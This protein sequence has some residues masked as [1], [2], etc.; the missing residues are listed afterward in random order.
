MFGRKKARVEHRGV[1]PGAYTSAHLEAQRT[2]ILGQAASAA[3]SSAAETGAG[4]LARAISSGRV[5]AG[6]WSPLIT[7]ALLQGLVRGMVYTGEAAAW[8][9]EAEGRF[10]FQ[11]VQHQWIDRDHLEIQE[12][13]PY[14][15]RTFHVPQA[16]VAVCLWSPNPEEPWRGISPLAHLGASLAANASGVLERESG[17]KVAHGYLLFHTPRNTFAPPSPERLAEVTEEIDNKLADWVGYEPGSVHSMSLS[18]G[19]VGQS[20]N[21]LG[22]Q[23]RFGFSPEMSVIEA[24]RWG[25]EETLRSLG[26]P[27]ILFSA[28]NPATRDSHRSFIA[29]TAQPLANAIASEISRVLEEPVSIDLSPVRAADDVASR[30][31]AMM[32]M[33]SAG[34]SP[35]RAEMVAGLSSGIMSHP[36]PAN[37][38]NPPL[39]AANG[40]MRPG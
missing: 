35:E 39:V 8:F 32:N 5:E 10:Y 7:P 37:A 17:P 19:F 31:R 15:T 18:E 28:T 12:R 29:Q 13:L 16:S 26:V 24:A 2:F 30:A 6:R 9:R 27:L 14:R 33:V 40:D 20:E 34:M 4:L 25:C 3:A 38:G 22:V 1:R 23:S 21:R 36:V 11:Q